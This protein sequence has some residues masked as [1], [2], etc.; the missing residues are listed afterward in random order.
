MTRP[1][2]AML[3]A[4][5]GAGCGRAKAPDET[6]ESDAPVL[7]HVAKAGPAT[8]SV[9][10]K[11]P[12]TTV[13]APGAEIVIT[14][15]MQG[16]VAALPHG[17][18]DQVKAGDL[19]VQF[20]IPSLS[21][22]LASRQSALAQA[23]ARV[24]NA[25]AARDRLAGLL[26][27]GIAARREVEDAERDLAEAQAGVQ[28]ASAG[29]E[30]ARQMQARQRV[31]APFDG[32]VVRRLHNPGD[33]VDAS[34]ADPIL[35]FAD[36]S[37][38]EVEAQVPATAVPRIKAGESAVVTGAGGMTWNATV[39]RTPAAVDTATSSARVRLT[40]DEAA[41]PPLGLPVEA[42]I[43]VASHEAGVAVPAAAV[44]REGEK[45]SVYVV[46]DGKAVRHD[47]VTGLASDE[48]VEILKGVTAGDSVIVDGLDGLPD[49][50]KVSV[51]P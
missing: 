12:G 8:V 51:A 44:V 17:E 16:R 34:A 20:E 50:A 19:L 15:P 4:L 22:D 43:V 24:A 9:A 27:R 45:V 35:R 37:R 3:I 7:V 48:N 28:E 41:R 10:V 21:A 46:T 11:A 36:P 13:S 30:S 29:L 32:V 23:K 1:V 40:L 42:S 26:T 38:R 39:A 18:G 47:A 31:T 5:V 14:A 6:V 33:L 49:G 25:Q 2:C